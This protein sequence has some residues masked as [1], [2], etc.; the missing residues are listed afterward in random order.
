MAGHP[1]IA[2]EGESAKFLNEVLEELLQEVQ[3]NKTQLN[4]NKMTKNID[5]YV[6]KQIS[7]I[8]ERIF[9]FEHLY[10]SN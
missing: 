3:L 5:V 2:P 9:F 4:K 8:L 1:G 10:R 6:M 7:R